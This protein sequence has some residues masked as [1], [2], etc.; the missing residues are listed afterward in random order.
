MPKSTV[1]TSQLKAH[2]SKIID[3]VARK[4][5]VVEITERGETVAMIIPAGIDVPVL[6]FG[7]AKGCISVYGDILKPVEARSETHV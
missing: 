1:S 7:F 5:N 6:L 3:G 4:R 2:C